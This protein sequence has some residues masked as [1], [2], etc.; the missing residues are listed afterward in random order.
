[1]KTCIEW[2]LIKICFAERNSKEEKNWNMEQTFLYSVFIMTYCEHEE[3][4]Q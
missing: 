4:I 1:M 2:A 3:N